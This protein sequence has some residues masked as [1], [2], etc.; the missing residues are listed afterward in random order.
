[1]SAQLTWREYLLLLGFIPF[2]CTGLIIAS[3]KGKIL[4]PLKRVIDSLC[5]A[6][7]MRL[8]R[9]IPHETKAVRAK[10]LHE[11]LMSPLIGCIWCM[12]S[13]HTAI[14][15]VG[16]KIIFKGQL[17]VS[18]FYSWI[19]LAIPSIVLNGSLFNL[20]QLLRLTVNMLEEKH[21][22]KEDGASTY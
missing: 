22:K 11:Y 16:Y 10:I 6:V 3:E 5:H 14:I 13:V 20:V 2:W 18:V 9:N 15:L 1:M 7:A 8:T 12:A 17:D 4:Y 21:N 19:I